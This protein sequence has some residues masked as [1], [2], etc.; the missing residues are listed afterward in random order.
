MMRGFKRGTLI[1][2]LRVKEVKKLIHDNRRVGDRDFLDFRDITIKTNVVK[3]AYGSAY[4]SIGDTIAIAGV[5]FDIGTPFADSPDKGI[6]IS[7]GEVLPTAS[8]YV[9]PGPPTEEEIELSRIIDRGIRGSGMIDLSK[10][11]IVPGEKV[12]KVFIDFNILNDDGNLVDAASLAAVAALLTS[13]YPDPDKLLNVESAEE[14]STVDRIP[15]PIEDIPITIT[16]AVIDGKY[17]V[18]PSL[19]EE[20]AADAILSITHTKNDEICA[21]QLLNGELDYNQ[22]FDILDIALEKSR[23]IRNYVLSHINKR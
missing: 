3:K 1:D 21:M 15:L 6:L 18:D 10:M 20:V 7:E 13:N 11:V 9:E 19:P 17:L 8:F 14:L 5:H 16:T 4:V 23:E 12:L 22:L 2:I